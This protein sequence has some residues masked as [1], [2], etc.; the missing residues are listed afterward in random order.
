MADNSETTSKFT[1]R[2]GALAIATILL[3]LTGW[4]RIADSERHAETVARL[5]AKIDANQRLV[6]ER[7]KVVF[8]GLTEIRETD[9]ALRIRTDRLESRA[10]RA[11]AERAA[12][13]QHSDRYSDKIDRIERDQI[14][15]M[16]RLGFLNGKNDDPVFGAKRK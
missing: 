9:I 7:C 15:L 14:E 2:D 10:E 6:D 12:H 16:R 13:L 3:L 4:L 5:D 1:W 8:D 11:D